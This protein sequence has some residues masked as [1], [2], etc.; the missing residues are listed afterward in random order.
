MFCSHICTIWSVFIMLHHIYGAFPIGTN[1]MKFQFFYRNINDRELI[2]LATWHPCWASLKVSPWDL[3]SMINGFG[4]L[5]LRGSS[6]ANN[7]STRSLVITMLVLF[8]I[9]LG[10]ETIWNEANCQGFCVKFG[11]QESYDQLHIS[12]KNTQLRSSPSM[13]YCM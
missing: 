1:F 10:F 2:E 7:F 11:S 13:V 3:M 5:I 4:H 12:K 8:S 6:Q 9:I